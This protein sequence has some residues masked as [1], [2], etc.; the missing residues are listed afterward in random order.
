MLRI[1]TGNFA[2]KF[3]LLGG[4]TLEKRLLKT[5]RQ[6]YSQDR[7]LKFEFMIDYYF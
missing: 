4:L 3:K 6:M 2:P 1:T 7:V 5:V